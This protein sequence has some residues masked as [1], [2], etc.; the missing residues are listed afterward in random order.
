MLEEMVFPSAVTSSTSK[1][2]AEENLPKPLCIARPLSSKLIKGILLLGDITG[3]IFSFI[4][5]RIILRA[6][7]IAGLFTSWQV[8][9]ILILTITTLW[10]LDAIQMD[11][12]DKNWRIVVKFLCGLALAAGIFGISVYLLGPIHWAGRVGFWGRRTLVLFVLIFTVWGI[13]QRFLLH[14][15]Q[16]RRS[17]RARW[18]LLGRHDARGLAPFW[19]DFQAEHGHGALVFLAESEAET[20]CQSDE[21]PEIAGTWN[22][23]D[24][25]LGEPWSGIIVADANA[26]PPS[27]SRILMHARLNGMLVKSIDQFCE[28]RWQRLPVEYLRGDWFTFA[29]GFDLVQSPLNARAKRLFDI[30]LAGTLLLIAGLPMLLLAI[31]LKLLYP[32]PVFYTQPR[33]GKNKRIFTCLKFRSMHTS[34]ADDGGIY[35]TTNDKRVTRLGRLMRKTR[36]DELPQLWNILRGD[37]SFIGPRAEW[38]KC[39]ANYENAIPFYH[40][41]HLVPPGLTGWAQIN[42]PYGA[43]VED[44]RVKLTYDLWYIKNHNLLLDLLIVLRTVRVVLFGIGG[45]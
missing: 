42:Y 9:T 41:R 20:A 34:S 30:L 24:E 37:M 45:R 8:A 2:A 10:L 40:L 23:L 44:A 17:G 16:R 31:S 33:V 19:R 4:L 3:I 28:R 38:T 14:A 35:T 15:W 1:D 7:H 36:M 22:G 21:H 25:K 18:L 26:L 6:D 39:V 32:G 29:G 11:V 13:L 43:S 12:E 27:V 5:A